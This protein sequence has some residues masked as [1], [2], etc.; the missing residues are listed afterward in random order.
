MKPYQ[1]ADLRA[2]FKCPYGLS[3]QVGMLSIR[4]TVNL[5][6]SPDPNWREKKFMGFTMISPENKTTELCKMYF[7]TNTQ[8]KRYSGVTCPVGVLEQGVMVTFNQI[9]LKAYQLFAFS[10]FWEAPASGGR[11]AIRIYSMKWFIE[12]TIYNTR[13]ECIKTGEAKAQRL[14]GYDPKKALALAPYRRPLPTSCH[15]G[16]IAGMDVVTFRAYLDVGTNKRWLIKKQFGFYRQLPDRST[17]IECTLEYTT[18]IEYSMISFGPQVRSCD[19]FIFKDQSWVVFVLRT[20]VTN[21]YS[22]TPYFFY[23]YIPSLPG[24]RVT[25]RIVSNPVFIIDDIFD[26]G[27]LCHATIMTRTL[28]PNPASEMPVIKVTPQNRIPIPK[29]CSYGLVVALDQIRMH[30]VLILKEDHIVLEDKEYFDWYLY[31]Q[32]SFIK[33][34]SDSGSSIE[35]CTMKFDQEDPEACTASMKTKSADCS[36]S[37]TIQY[38]RSVVF[39]LTKT[40]ETADK[41]NKYYLAWENHDIDTDSINP[42]PVKSPAWGVVDNIF[43]SKT[44]CY[45]H[46]MRAAS[47]NSGANAIRSLFTG[48]L[49]LESWWATVLH[50]IVAW[51]ITPRLY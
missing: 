25:D 29:V 14:K 15:H 35:L 36:C 3:H 12:E 44:I 11:P 33:S 22:V 6:Q 2:D 13:A 42:T 26:E 4:A 17:E 39:N 24:V 46:G 47:K 49:A 16:L 18:V 30:A 27:D 1:T 23:Y 38:P 37:L 31:K 9:T 45:E 40:V 21:E 28:D 50:L 19:A 8:F 34:T 10:F 32:F 48:L 51:M 20:T 7:S 41:N 5:S 43:D